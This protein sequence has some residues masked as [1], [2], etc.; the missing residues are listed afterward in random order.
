MKTSWLSGRFKPFVVE[1]DTKTKQCETVDDICTFL[2]ENFDHKPAP[3]KLVH[4]LDDIL[5]GTAS[6]SFCSSPPSAENL[7]KDKIVYKFVSAGGRPA[8]GASIEQVVLLRNGELAELSDGASSDGSE[9][10]AAEFFEDEEESPC[11]KRKKR[12]DVEVVDSAGRLVDD[13]GP[14]TDGPAAKRQK[15]G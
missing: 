2:V 12:K 7:R 9:P 6:N 1:C 15:A 11:N 10:S 13:G 8:P 5:W 14:G 4:A 3:E